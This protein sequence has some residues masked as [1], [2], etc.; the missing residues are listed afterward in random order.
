MGGTGGEQPIECS[1]VRF[2]SG[3]SDNIALSVGH[4]PILTHFSFPFTNVSQGVIKDPQ[5]ILKNSMNTTD[6]S[7]TPEHQAFPNPGLTFA[8]GPVDVP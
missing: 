5:G 2:L 7:D 6:T 1:S 4:S 8:K 3:Y